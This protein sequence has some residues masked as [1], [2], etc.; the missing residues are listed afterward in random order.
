VNKTVLFSTH[1]LQEVEALCDKVIV[2]NKGKIV[3]DDSLASLM[4]GGNYIVVEFGGVVDEGDLAG[5]AGVSAVQRLD[6]QR[7]RLRSAMGYDVRREVTR[8]AYEKNLSL[9]G[10]KQDE[11]SL[12]SVFREL[13]K[14]REEQRA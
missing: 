11:N 2:I 10:L 13:T 4:K 12:E 9:V 1:I 6:A 5:I 8:F 3:A 14:S 7:F